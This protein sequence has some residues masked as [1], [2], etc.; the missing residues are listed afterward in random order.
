MLERIQQ[1]FP[2]GQCHYLQN[3]TPLRG[4][5]I[6][7]G[8]GNHHARIKNA[9]GSF[10]L[11]SDTF[12]GKTKE[13]NRAYQCQDRDPGTKA[14]LQGI[15]QEAALSDPA[16]PG[17]QDIACARLRYPPKLVDLFVSGFKVERYVQTPI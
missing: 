9:P 15:V 2:V 1:H 16:G 6:P 7:A 5:P 12:P 10:D 3:R 4:V 17:L 13:G 14:K 11:G 8:A